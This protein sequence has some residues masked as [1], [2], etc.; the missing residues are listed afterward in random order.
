MM[1][2]S[3]T[4]RV[5]ALDVAYDVEREK[6][7][8]FARAVGE[9]SS[10]CHDPAAAQELGYPDVVAP[11]TFLA[12]LMQRATDRVV[13]DPE[14]GLEYDRVLHRD[15]QIMLR[16]PVCAGDRLTAE[17]HIDAVRS[18]AGNDV[19]E[20]R[21]EMSTSDGTRAVAFFLSLVVR[22]DAALS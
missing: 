13:F 11:P 14:I 7:R 16:R 1:R 17:V 9:M 8:E 12:V 6:V 15:Q 3:L 21:V 5:Y 18:L 10:A 22:A 19:L 2:A 20:L 4:G